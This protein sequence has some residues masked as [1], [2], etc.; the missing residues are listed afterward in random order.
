MF[1]K[2]KITYTMKKYSQLKLESWWQAKSIHLKCGS[3][4][5]R[6]IHHTQYDTSRIQMKYD[7]QN[8]CLDKCSCSSRYKCLDG[9][10]V[11]LRR[12]MLWSW[13]V[14][15]LVSFHCHRWGWFRR[16]C[17]PGKKSFINQKLAEKPR[18][19]K[20][21]HSQQHSMP[22]TNKYNPVL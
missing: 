3:I 10:N 11:F 9:W 18:I 19:A 7:S 17:S 6:K 20:G 14:L 1:P 21:F 4:S 8:Y 5:Y 16:C 15:K 12:F 13:D 2:T 22:S